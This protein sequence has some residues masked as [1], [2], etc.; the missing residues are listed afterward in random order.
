MRWCENFFFL[1]QRISYYLATVRLWESITTSQ[2]CQDHTGT[3]GKILLT[4]GPFSDT[5]E[6]IAAY[7]LIECSTRE[8]AIEAAAQHPMAKTATIEVRPIW[9]DLAN[10]SNLGW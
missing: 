5:S 8:E 4:A 7:V 1:D 9:E 2:R 10:F 3:K 6:K